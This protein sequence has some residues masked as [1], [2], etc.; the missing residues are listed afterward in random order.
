MVWSY[1][2]FGRRHDECGTLQCSKFRLKLKNMTKLQW[3][4][5]VFI[6]S[7]NLQHSIVSHSS[8]QRPVGI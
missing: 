7:R 2:Y 3:F 4:G 1:F 6:C 5:P 8:W